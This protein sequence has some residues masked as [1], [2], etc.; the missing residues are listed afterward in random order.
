MLGAIWIR[1]RYVI[2]GATLA[3][4]HQFLPAHV[5]TVPLACLYFGPGFAT[6]IGRE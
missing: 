4:R 5:A 1:Y 6:A 3:S 2:A